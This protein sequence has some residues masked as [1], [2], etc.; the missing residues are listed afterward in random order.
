MKEELVQLILARLKADAAPLREAFGASTAKVGVR[1]CTIDNLLPAD[2][3]GRIAE[4]FP[5]LEQ[6]RLMDSF[7]DR[8]YTSKKFEQVDPLMADIT[9]AFQDPRI[10][11]AVQAITGIQHQMPD[12]SHHADGLSAMTRGHFL[13]PHID[14]T[15]DG[16][17]QNDR[18]LYLLYHVTPGCKGESGG[19]LEL[20]NQPATRKV[21]IESRFNR[22]ARIKTT[23]ISSHSVNPIQADG[24]RRCVSNH[25][26]SPLSRTGTDYFNITAFSAR[27][28]QKPL[29]VVAWAAGKLRQARPRVVPGALRRKDA[30]EAPPH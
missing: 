27:P 13:G 25:Y 5:K 19:H 11:A 15:H 24:V 26:F 8:K 21:P 14:N 9:F 1:F 22:L 18:T 20:W 16:A 4:A 6:M 3:A 23:P 17:R 7:R 28:A 30:Y 12:S 10:V 2:I 29:R